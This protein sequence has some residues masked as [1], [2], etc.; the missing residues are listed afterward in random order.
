MR[1]S[2]RLSQSRV[3]EASI[4]IITSEVS[5]SEKK[6]SPGEK[7]PQIEASENKSKTQNLSLEAKY[8]I[9]YVIIDSDKEFDEIEIYEE[10]KD[11]PT[12]QD[13]V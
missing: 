7:L 8:S 4:P 3:L 5:E 11:N 13:I 12:I 2:A 6:L 9:N 1:K 10:F